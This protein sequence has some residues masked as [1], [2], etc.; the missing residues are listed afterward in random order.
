MSAGRYLDGSGAVH[1]GQV[2]GKGG[3]GTVSL[4]EDRPGRVAKIYHKPPA[5]EKAEK[6]LAMSG[7]ATDGLLALAAWPVDVLRDNGG[8]VLGAVMPAVTDHGDIHALYSP[9]SRKTEFPAADFRFLVRV[10]ANVS[11][12]FA[13]VHRT[14]CVIGDVNHGGVRVSRRATVSLIDCDSFQVTCGD[15][16]FPC[17]VGVPTFTPPELQGSSLRGAVRKTDHDAFGLA[18]MVFLLL[19]MGRHPFAGRYVGKGD[20]SIE[21]AIR[22]FRF[23][24]GADKA[25]TQ[26]EP[27]PNTPPL[28]I[29]SD[30]V[31]A[32]FEAAFGPDGVRDGRPTPEQWIAALTALEGRLRQCATEPAHWHIDGLGQCPWCFLERRSGTLLFNTLV[33]RVV[34]SAFDL[35]AAW[36]A[37]LAVQSPGLAPRISSPAATPSPEMRRVRR[38]RTLAWLSGG[39]LIAWFVAIFTDLQPVKVLDI[40][41]ALL[42]TP[43]FLRYFNRRWT[44]VSRLQYA[45]DK[46][47]I[48]LRYKL[49]RWNDDASDG[50]FQEKL[51]DLMEVRD[52]VRR[53]P[54]ERQRRYQML[55]RERERRQLDG[56]LANFS[57]E[58]AA[59]P[60]VGPGRK[61]ML[62]SYNIETAAD[63]DTTNVRKVPGFGPALTEEMVKW[64]RS[65]EKGF[66]FDPG[67]GID[68][69]AIKALDQEIAA[70]RQE[71]EKKLHAGPAALKRIRRQ[72]L[73]DRAA[74]E[75][76]LRTALA[77]EAQAEVDLLAAKG[78]AP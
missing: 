66:R 29:A 71:L 42:L 20:M 72:I 74:L 30:E 65:M 55:E 62:E 1:L 44:A 10:A 21:Q 16:R 9:R 67:K 61:A 45:R 28:S 24:Y 38:S 7:M 5:P 39:A 4:I 54:Q 25:R 69:A 49:Q 58:T 70:M 19:F 27:P 13:A 14:G 63:V 6:L 52:N 47:Q 12:A 51:K 22:E 73:N 76:Q 23:A 68:A 53:I 57:I 77:A 37:I 78:R 11:R 60:G 43:I 18:V 32:L 26:M 34:A 35:D 46:A 17:D 50:R 40:P 2:L 8:R 75:P 36:A 15:Q 48:D 41:G 31:A 33:E 56:W 59:I 3:E 64:R